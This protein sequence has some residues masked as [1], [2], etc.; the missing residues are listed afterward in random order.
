MVRPSHVQGQALKQGLP[1]REGAAAGKEDHWLR[2]QRSAL[3]PALSVN[4][5]F[6]FLPL[7]A[8]VSLPALQLMSRLCGR[9]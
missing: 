2:P 4:A 5:I 8:A 7:A 6:G 9:V 3:F 1:A